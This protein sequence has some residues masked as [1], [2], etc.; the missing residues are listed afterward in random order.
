MIFQVVQRKS[1]DIHNSQVFRLAI[2]VEQINIDRNSFF[3][4]GNTR[5]QANQVYSI[6]SNMSKFKI[7]QPVSRP[8]YNHQWQTCRDLDIT[9]FTKIRQV[10]MN[11]LENRFFWGRLGPCSRTPN[12][13][14]SCCL[15]GCSHMLNNRLP[16]TELH[17]FPTCQL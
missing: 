15:R 1:N 10:L 17:D 3:L 16:G 7:A 8:S 14:L 6:C 11:F 4:W 2:Q 13:P 12:A 5:I 9:Q